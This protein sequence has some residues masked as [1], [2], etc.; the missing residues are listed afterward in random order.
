MLYISFII[1]PK[2]IRARKKENDRIEGIS[3]AGAEKSEAESQSHGARDS[4]TQETAPQCTA[5]Y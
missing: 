3:L 5:T 1:A 2:R 4:H